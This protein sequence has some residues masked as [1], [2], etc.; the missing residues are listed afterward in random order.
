M[1]EDKNDKPYSISIA[2]AVERY[3]I[4]KTVIYELIAEGKISAFKL[5]TKTLIITDEM[6]AYISGLP[7]WVPMPEKFKWREEQR[8]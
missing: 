1:T 3:G 4:G 7:R 6:D 2:G 8:A 5:G